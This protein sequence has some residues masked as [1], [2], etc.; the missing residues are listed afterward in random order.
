MVDKTFLINTDYFIRQSHSLVFI[1][2]KQNHVPH[3]GLDP[4]IHSS[5]I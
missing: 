4:N 2:D 1:K 5:F 3:K